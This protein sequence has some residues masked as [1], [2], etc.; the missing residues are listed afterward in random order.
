MPDP[1][2]FYG[3]LREAVL[4][5]VVGWDFSWIQARV[6]RGQFPWNYTEMVREL[7]RGSP[8]L[9][10][11][12]TGGGEWLADLV[13]RPPR[14]VATESYGPNVPVA[15]KRLGPRTVDVVYTQDVPDNVRQEGSVPT[16]L[17]FHDRSFHL[18][19]DRHEAFVAGEVARVLARGG[20]FLTQQV[21]EG[22]RGEWSRWFGR[23]PPPA[24]PRSWGLPLARAQLEGAGLRV[25]RSGS[26]SYTTE[27]R[28][29]GA[30]VWYLRA[31]PWA[32]P[33]FSVDRD[34]DV[35]RRLH[36]KIQREGSL[37]VEHPGFF[38]EATHRRPS[39]AGKRTRAR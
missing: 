36:Q 21:G 25:E 10:D 35:L 19:V 38:V 16:H 39:R 24:G 26:G 6:T 12:G 22:G 23:A 1:P 33:G 15:R 3:M 20:T 32:L 11:L 37:K 2:T 8:D 5:P 4:R 29:I 7:A 14:T 27:F 34:V 13:P 30:V 28:D 18:I 17:P 9:L 31:V